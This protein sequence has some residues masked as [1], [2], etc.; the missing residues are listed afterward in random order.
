MK[1]MKNR[2]I[3]LTLLLLTT[4]L[5]WQACQETELTPSGNDGFEPQS[6]IR[7]NSRKNLL[8]DSAIFETNPAVVM[9]FLT[10]NPIL[11]TVDTSESFQYQAYTVFKQTQGSGGVVTWSDDEPPFHVEGTFSINTIGV[12]FVSISKPVP[13][14]FSLQLY[15]LGTH[16]LLTA[17]NETGV[18]SIRNIEPMTINPV[19]PYH[20]VWG[21]PRT[22]NLSNK[23]DQFEFGLFEVVWKP[24]DTQDMSKW[25]YGTFRVNNQTPH[26]YQ[27]TFD[28]GVRLLLL[29][30]RSYP[31]GT[32][33]LKL[34]AHNPVEGAAYGGV[35]LGHMPPPPCNNCE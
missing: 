12:A 16:S 7:D 33:L 17:T 9:Q 1:N 20:T 29:Q 15:Y 21:E 4:T 26:L 3:R 14:S 24:F 23:F 31:T 18:Q 22:H 6:I 2:K 35:F 27:V 30:Y 28:N 8:V 5:C 32:L 25:V 34:D 13:I 11:M 10:K 19:D